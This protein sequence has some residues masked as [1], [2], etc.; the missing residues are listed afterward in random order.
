MR[1]TVGDD[2]TLAGII[3]LVDEA[4][5]QSIY[6]A[7]LHDKALLASLYL[8]SMELRSA[9]FGSMVCLRGTW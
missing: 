3:R 2:I 1:A 7:S 8:L 6:R 9:T 4:K 5:A